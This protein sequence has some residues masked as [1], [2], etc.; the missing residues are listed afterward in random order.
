MF[1]YLHIANDMPFLKILTAL[2]FKFSLILIEQRS[3]TDQ[4]SPNHSLILQMQSM[5]SVKVA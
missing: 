5:F 2:L 3:S 4:Y 1:K